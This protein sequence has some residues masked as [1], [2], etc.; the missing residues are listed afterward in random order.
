MISNVDETKNESTLNKIVVAFSAVGSLLATTVGWILRP[1]FSV[2]T[3]PVVVLL[4]AVG[5]FLIAGTVGTGVAPL[6]N[7]AETALENV[8]SIA[9][10]GGS[11]SSA[12]GGSGAA[13]ST[14]E[15]D[16]GGVLDDSL[17]ET[18]IE[19]AVHER[20]NQVRQQRGLQ[21]LNHDQRLQNIAD[22]HSED[23]AERG[24]YSHTAPDGSD[25][26]DRYEAA[27][28]DC[29]ISIN[30]SW[31]TSGS[32]NIAYTF[33]DTDVRTASGETVDHDGNETK[34]GYGIVRQW[35]NSQGHRENIL[36]GYWQNEGIGIAVASVDGR[37][38]VYATQN[39]C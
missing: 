18:A 35:M 36:R 21:P 10:L 38:K 30:S 34:I 8:E 29:R 33:A 32:E 31:H 13:D 5:L 16:A 4:A 20:V 17:N 2:V 25:F 14:S 6:D 3:N 37:Q 24:Y 7:G 12:S 9:V 11:N 39:F 28:Y 26:S 1:I 15:S 27:N 23:M 19:L 22:G